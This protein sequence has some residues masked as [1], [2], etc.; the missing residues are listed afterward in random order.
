MAYVVTDACIRCKYMECVE[1]C[2]V[3][4]FAAGDMML[5]IDPARCIDCGF[6]DPVC[7]ANAIVHDSD[8]RAQHWLT[9][10]R[11]YAAAWPP[12]MRR[13]APCAD[14]DNWKGRAGKGAMF[15]DEPAR[16]A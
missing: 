5:V 14:A 16:L 6:C 3:G 4:C 7:P 1:A 10:N 9:I 12:I 8:P 15:T 11:R 13:Q 2:P